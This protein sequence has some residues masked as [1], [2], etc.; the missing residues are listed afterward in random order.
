[1]AAALGTMAIAP[2]T[3]SW[4]MDSSA[5]H[6]AT[7][8]ELKPTSLPLLLIFAAEDLPSPS[9]ARFP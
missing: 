2:G 4:K 6:T 8:E 9:P 1:M 3:A 5:E 7:P